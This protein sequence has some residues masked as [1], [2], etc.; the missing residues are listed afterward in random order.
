LKQI[1]IVLFVLL[2]SLTALAQSTGFTWAPAFPSGYPLEA[3]DRGPVG[4]TSS[5]EWF[6]AQEGEPT[7]EEC[8]KG[9]N[10]GTFD[11]EESCDNWYSLLRCKDSQCF[12]ADEFWNLNKD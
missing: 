5:L 4:F 8:L 2:T 10:E 11:Y 7:R 1:S 6:I 9:I 3:I 12:I